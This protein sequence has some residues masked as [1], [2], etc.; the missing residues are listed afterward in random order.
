[1]LKI[2]F[3]SNSMFFIPISVLKRIVISEH[4]KKYIIVHRIIKKY[5]AKNVPTILTIL[6]Y[7]FYELQ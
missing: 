2:V 7:Y 1:M 3:G 5:C 6:N 4:N